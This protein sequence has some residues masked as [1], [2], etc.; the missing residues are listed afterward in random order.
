[1]AALG[2]YQ[3]ETATLRCGR[4]FFVGCVWEGGGDRNLAALSNNHSAAKNMVVKSETTP[5]RQGS[6]PPTDDEPRR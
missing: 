6:E 4:L 1:M 2:G 3:I 5:H